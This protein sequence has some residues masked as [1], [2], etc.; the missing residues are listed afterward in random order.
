MDVRKKTR[1]VGLIHGL[2]VGGA[3]RMM[4]TILNYFLLEGFEV[5]L[6]IF[7]NSGPLKE[8]LFDE[9]KVYDL[10]SSSVMKGIPKCLR[11]LYEIKVDIIF[12]GIGHLNIALAP[13]I[14]FMNLLLPKRKW[15]ARE[16]SIVSLHNQA[17]K[18]PKL[19]DFLYRY[20]YINYDVIIAQSE[21]MKSDLEINYLKSDK[22][23][24]INN[25]VDVLKVNRLANEEKNISF[26]NKKINLLMVSRLREEKRHDLM[27]KTLALL[28]KT[29]YLTI[30]G[31]GEQE[32]ALK[33][34]AKALNL[35]ERVS[36]EGYQ[37]NPYPYMKEADLFLLTSQRE[38]FPNVL[39]EANLLGLPIVA[40]SS[41][42]GITEIISEGIN[43]FYVPFGDCE[44]MAKQIKKAAHFNFDKNEI[45]ERTLFKYNKDKILK[46]YKKIFLK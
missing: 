19:F 13:F 16:T 15:I 9:I 2:D 34:L 25:P 29:Y 45:I 36:F 40:F 27:L 28:P 3:E 18:Y 38:G 39:L 24:T 11:F 46:K 22:I 4:V 23:V 1:L 41:M 37:S 14:P 44:A 6:I 8:E 42:G 7:E 33:A 31:S 43:G 26:N 20:S 35:L 21:N 32:V 10:N 5:H 12:T 17:S 30:V